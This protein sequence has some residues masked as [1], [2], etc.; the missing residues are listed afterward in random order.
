MKKKVSEL[1]YNPDKQEPIPHLFHGD[2][3]ITSYSFLF[4]KEWQEKFIA[5]FGDQELEYDE[6]W[7]WEC[8]DPDSE[9]YKY[10]KDYSSAKLTWCGQNTSE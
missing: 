8:K 4:F 10:Q 3:Y 5:K 6:H 9:F 7:G 1:V 2:A